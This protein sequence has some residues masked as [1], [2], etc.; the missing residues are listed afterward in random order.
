MISVFNY[1]DFVELINIM[2][3][4]IF[5]RFQQQQQQQNYTK[6]LIFIE[7]VDFLVVVDLEIIISLLF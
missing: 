7:L 5:E 6:I 1:I 2:L 4:D 3:D